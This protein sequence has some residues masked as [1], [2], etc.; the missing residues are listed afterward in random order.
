M[1]RK[2]AAEEAAEAV[3]TKEEMQLDDSAGDEATPAHAAEHA[4]ANK[5]PKTEDDDVAAEPKDAGD[6]A[7]ADAGEDAAA[8][9]KAEAGEDAGEA[10]GDDEDAGAAGADAGNRGDARDGEDVT[11]RLRISGFDKFSQPKAVKKFLTKEGVDFRNVKKSPKWEYAIVGFKTEAAAEDCTAKISGKQFKKNKLVVEQMS[12]NR[13]QI[14][15]RRGNEMTE[16]DQ[17]PVFERLNDQVCRLWRKTTE[18]Q[19]AAH[20]DEMRSTLVKFRREIFATMTPS[21]KK[22]KGKDNESEPADAPEEASAASAE[23]PELLEWYKSASRVFEGQTQ[24]F[25]SI[26]P[27]PVKLGYRNKVEFTFGRDPNG[28]V[29]VGFLLG[30]FREG[31]TAVVEPSQCPNVSDTAKAIAK[32]LEDLAES[33]DQAVFP[34]YDRVKKAGFWR[35]AMVR[36]PLTGENLIFIQVNPT[37]IAADVLAAEKA[38]IV[39]FIDDA[40]KAKGF[41]VKTVL[42]QSTDSMF[43]GFKAEQPFELLKGDGYVHEKLLGHNFRISPNSFFQVNTKAT[44][45]LY[46]KVKDLCLTEPVV[47][48]F[49]EDNTVVS[50]PPKQLDASQ[51]VLLDLCSGTG[52]IGIT[53]A[54]HFKKVVGIEI[55]AEAVEDAKHNAKLNKIK[56]A[57]FVCG[58]VEAQLSAVLAEHVGPTDHLVAVLDPARAGLP[59]SVMQTLRKCARLRH[60]VYVACAARL[61]TT[62]FIELCRPTSNRFGGEPFRPAEATPVEL[63]PHTNSCELVMSF[64]RWKYEM[65]SGGLVSALSGLKKEM[66]FTWIGWPGLELP[67][68]EQ[69]VVSQQLLEQYSCAPVFINNDIADKHYNGFS[70]S[71]LWPLFHYHPGE[72]NFNEDHWEAYQIANRAFADAILKVVEDGDLVWVHDYHLMLLPAMLRKGLEATGKSVK[73]GFFLHTPFPSSEI[74]RILP[75]RKQV[76]LG[77]LSCDL[78]GFHTYDYARHFLSSCTRILGLHTMPNGAEF[79][80][81]HVHVGTFPIG[82]DPS[83]F[84]MVRAIRALAWLAR[85]LEQPAIRDRIERLRA[86]FAGVKVLVGVD[87]LDY[88]KGVP[89]KLHAFELFLSRH[90]EWIEKVVLVQ[91]AVPSREDVEEYQHLQ[92]VVNELVGRINGRFGTVEFT[93]IH[94]MHKSVNFQELVSLYAVADACIVSSTRDG[95]NLVSYEYIVSQ[96]N[97][98]GVLILSEFAGAAQSLN[99]SII[100]NP[101]NT[102]DL[103]EGIFDA[104]TMPED[105]RKANHQ[106]L[107]RYVNKYTAAFWG[108]SFVT[109]MQRV[110]DEYDPRKLPKV[111]TDQVLARFKGSTKKKILLLDYDGTLTEL[112]N[113][114]EFARPSA[115]VLTLLARLAAMPNVYVYVFSGRSREH[116]ER[117]FG[118]M[119]IGLCAEHGCFFRH[120][121]KVHLLQ[122][123][124]FD[125]DG[126]SSV[127]SLDPFDLDVK[128]SAGSSASGGSGGDGEGM[129]AGAAA[130]GFGGDADGAAAAAAAAA[131]IEASEV[132]VAGADDAAAE[133]G[134]L[135]AH[136]GAVSQHRRASGNGWFAM[137][138]QFDS[139]WRGTIMPLFQHYTERT[140]GSFI[141]EKD[142]ILTWHYRN[143]DPEFGMWQATELQVNL[144]KLLS[145]LA[146]SI[147]LGNKTLELRPSMVDKATSA[148]SILKDLDAANDCDFLLCVGDGKTD[149]VLFA[150][151]DETEPAFTVTVGKKQT[152][153]KYYLENVADVERLLADIVACAGDA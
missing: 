36:T 75:V 67:P 69:A 10:A 44:E 140:P 77:V 138:D 97:S 9:S 101:W 96:K 22:G 111:A 68:D 115:A 35:I 148:R 146:V 33:S 124:G 56:N 47:P 43:V 128:H 131:T 127:G 57:E 120:P 13:N 123:A 42:F 58:G 113:M 147:V 29:A 153:A 74:Y 143:A 50:E 8:D 18:E 151:L 93:P 114:P 14:R 132:A 145:H 105:V 106:K 59:T 28:E 54:K 38:R 32:I 129:A 135:G 133:S 30:G 51:V 85:G 134:M 55:V 3:E 6:D 62:N 81:R 48:R 5:K 21:F 86:K 19:L 149:E 152:D 87:R 25:N 11:F 89:Q 70:N 119:G 53:L 17:R 92:Q 137:V 12:Q 39:P 126:Q 150:L 136:G 99:G 95:M 15:M 110:A 26:I 84:I 46:T 142:I 80:G 102:E 34:V 79:E 141:E 23:T 82:I 45:R 104:V 7:A 90:P 2:R 78:I 27:S 65:S 130:V 100:V 125:A 76:L 72:I 24:H 60:V 40:A 61:A 94:F 31:L 49:G 139:S 144:E 83:K 122:P 71:I 73:L 109:E 52:T 117:W 121:A 63:F 1:T 118:D 37:G 112:H 20:E 91:V 4:L 108:V 41:A 64:V 88:I 103:A 98:H 66:S 116:L 107:Y 16:D